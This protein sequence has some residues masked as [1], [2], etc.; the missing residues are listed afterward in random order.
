[1]GR[2]HFRLQ[3][4]QHLRH[5]AVR[6]QQDTLV[7]ESHRLE[8]LMEESTRLADE[9][10]RWSRRY[11]EAGPRGLPASEIGRIRLYLDELTRR[12]HQ[13]A[14]LVEEQENVVERERVRLVERVQEQ[15]AI[16]TLHDKRFAAFMQ[17][18]RRKSYRELEDR[19]ASAPDSGG[20]G[21]EIVP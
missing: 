10:T 4:V 14:G 18:E 9:F 6:E 21:K 7:R 19:M 2:F 1:M 12:I 16:D 11:L 20:S 8:G 5:H 17:E 13:N 3:A 15:R